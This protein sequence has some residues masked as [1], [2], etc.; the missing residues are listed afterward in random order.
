ML[1]R[2]DV[3][4]IGYESVFKSMNYFKNK[5]RESINFGQRKA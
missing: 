1:K 3:G 2:F 4:F 5:P